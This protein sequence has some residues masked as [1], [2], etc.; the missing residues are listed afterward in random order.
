MSFGDLKKDY[1][2]S[3]LVLDALVSALTLSPAEIS[4]LK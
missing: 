1:Q 2:D 4:D 3:L